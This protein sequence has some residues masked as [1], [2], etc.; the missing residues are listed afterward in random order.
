MHHRTLE[1]DLEPLERKHR[2]IYYDQRGGGESTLPADSALLT[3]D[4]H[5]RDLEAIRK[6]YGL[7]K[8]T[9]IGHSFGPAIA[10][11]Y[12]VRYPERVERMIFLG[13]I[14]PRKGTFF[15]EFGKTLRARLTDAQRQRADALQ[16]QFTSSK[17]PV[18]TC[19]EYWSIMIPPRVAKELPAK[20]VKSDMCDATGEAIVYGLSRTLPA[21]FASLGDWNWSGDLI[22]VKAQTLVIHGE[23]DAIPMSMVSEWA[24]ALP[25]ARLFRLPKTAHF[26]HAERP[27]IVFPA[28]E[29]FLQGRWPSTPP[30]KSRR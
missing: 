3:I 4:H 20:V 8:M 13:P 1:R 23:E 29:T 11:L 9:L 18:A 10:A 30:S 27:H 12:A 16:S 15:E 22:N 17:D 26:P 19:R 24:T 7:E 28:I 14:P 2:V 25:N 21:T 6:H 5:V